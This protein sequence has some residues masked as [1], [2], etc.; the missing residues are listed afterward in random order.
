[1]FTCKLG[2]FYYIMKIICN[3]SILWSNGIIALEILVFILLIKV[4]TNRMGSWYYLLLWDLIIAA[5]HQTGQ[6]QAG[7]GCR[8]G[9]L[10]KI[11][12]DT[13]GD[14]GYIM[15]KVRRKQGWIRSNR[16]P[17]I[18]STLGRKVRSYYAHNVRKKSRQKVVKKVVPLNL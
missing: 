2:N 8:A 13:P 14:T 17:V 12:M 16:I 1:M 11:I 7:Q 15:S 3:K 10:P 6:Q 9:T 4:K 5:A 18:L